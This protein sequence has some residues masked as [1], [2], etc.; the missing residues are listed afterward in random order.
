MVLLS[1]AVVRKYKMVYLKVLQS[2]QEITEPECLSNTAIVWRHASCKFIKKK[3]SAQVFSC[4]LC[5]IFQDTFFL[6]QFRVIASMFPDST[7]LHFQT[8]AAEFGW[9]FLTRSMRIA[10]SN[11]TMK[12]KY[13]SVWCEQKQQNDVIDIDLIY[14]SSLGIQW[15]GNWAL[16]F[17]ISLK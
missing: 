10:C 6:K 1:K 9:N 11:S 7:T 5:K 13:Q 12:T 8:V 15:T 17:K 4:K 16:T 14:I 3:T 2:L